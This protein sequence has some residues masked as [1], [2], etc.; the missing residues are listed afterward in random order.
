[1][2]T[3]SKMC[4]RKNKKLIKEALMVGGGER[5]RES[6]AQQVIKKNEDMQQFIDEETFA[7]CSTTRW[8]FVTQLEM[9]D[10]DDGLK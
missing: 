1:M 6:W 5:E 7:L 2:K 4:N 8:C 10:D 9:H 3:E